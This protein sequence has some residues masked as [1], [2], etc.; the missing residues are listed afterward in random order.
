MTI[1]VAE[2]GNEIT[3]VIAQDIATLEVARETT[4]VD[5]EDIIGDI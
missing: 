3:G 5:I 4:T 2:I 1:A